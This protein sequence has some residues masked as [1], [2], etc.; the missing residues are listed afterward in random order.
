MVKDKMYDWFQVKMDDLQQLFWEEKNPINLK[1]QFP[2]VLGALYGDPI[3]S[4]EEISRAPA[5]VQAF[6]LVS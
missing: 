1:A 4:R 5:E 3:K 6:K 2:A